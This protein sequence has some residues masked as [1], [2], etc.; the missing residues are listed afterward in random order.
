MRAWC[1]Q[2]ACLASV[3]TLTVAFANAPPAALRTDVPIPGS[4]EWKPLT[5]RSVERHTS[6]Q[7]VTVNGHKAFRAESE[8]A[9]SALVVAVGADTLNRTPI[10]RWRWR[11]EEP[12]EIEDE[13]SRAGDDFAARVYMLFRFEP[14]KSSWF[15][16]AQRG[17][18]ERLYGQ[19][20]PGNALNYVWSSRV[21]RG[22][23]WANPFSEQAR[24]VSLGPGSSE[25]TGGDVTDWREE[26][27]DLVADYRAQFGGE[28]PE[29]LGLAI[30][31]D[32]DN[33]CGR[34][35]AL[36]ADF[37]FVERAPDHAPKDR[38]VPANQ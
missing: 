34:A 4:G 16:R 29:P 36:F 21:A 3:L 28:P 14:E 19:E 6:Y 8:C 9:A 2:I 7:P 12:L 37:R 17:V 15:E 18:G 1:I 13:R 11:V 27:V 23:S 20:L 30:M 32:S 22:T 25:T 26:Q 24:M 31:T 5:F 35:R 38:P 10:L 33:S